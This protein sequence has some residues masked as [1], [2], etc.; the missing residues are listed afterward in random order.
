VISITRPDSSF[1]DCH[2]PGPFRASMFFRSW[3]G[4]DR[5]WPGRG[6][7]MTIKA[8]HFEAVSKIN[9]PA[10]AALVGR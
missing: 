9:A 7:G 5:E 3:A 8:D 4:K 1:T 6:L 10:R 2:G